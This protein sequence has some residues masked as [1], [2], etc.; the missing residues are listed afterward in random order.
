MNSAAA[1]EVRVD[2]DVVKQLQKIPQKDA[3]RILSM[4][5]ELA[6]NPYAGDV[7]KMQG[8]EDVWRRRVGAY[9]IFYEVL[10]EKKAVYVYQVERRTSTTY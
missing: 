4:I 5:A 7:R 10:S 6:T 2:R 9:R 1:W 8:E 3:K